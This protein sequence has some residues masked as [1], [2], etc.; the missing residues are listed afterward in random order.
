MC[1]ALWGHV[2]VSWELLPAINSAGGILCL[3]NDNSFRIQRKISGSGFILM[4]GEWV[5]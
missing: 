3:W 5:K 4:V 1:Q 2:H